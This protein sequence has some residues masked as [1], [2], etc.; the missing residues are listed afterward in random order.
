MYHLTKNGEL[1]KF[2]EE[3]E[4]KVVLYKLNK[5]GEILYEGVCIVTLKV[6]KDDIYSTSNN[7]KFLNILRDKEID[8]SKFIGIVFDIQTIV[9]DFFNNS[10]FFAR[11]KK[12][13]DYLDKRGLFLIYLYNADQYVIVDKKSVDKSITIK[14]F[15]P[16]VKHI[17]GRHGSNINR[18][19]NENNFK[20][21]SVKSLEAEEYQA[22]YKEFSKNILFVVNQ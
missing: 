9:Y 15:Y 1:G 6:N 10:D 13:S 5:N 12:I 14:A 3:Q 20:N 18:I 22:L 16:E 8:F 7:I 2:V 4:G 17:I 19:K 21:I 11:R